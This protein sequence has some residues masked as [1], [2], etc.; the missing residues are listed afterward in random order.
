M[1]PHSSLKIKWKC[2]REIFEWWNNQEHHLITKENYWPT[3]R[4]AWC[5]QWQKILKGSLPK[6]IKS[7]KIKCTSLVN[8]TRHLSKARM[9]LAIYQLNIKWFK[10]GISK[11]KLKQQKTQC[12]L[13]HLLHLVFQMTTKLE[14]EVKL[15]DGKKICMLKFIISQKHSITW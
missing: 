6:K 9:T 8:S 10:R 4:P 14:L 3:S 7:K 13:R 2:I 5:D 1:I 15:T 12:F 11:C